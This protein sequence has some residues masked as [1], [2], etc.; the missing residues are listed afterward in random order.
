MQP[1]HGS[2]PFRPGGAPVIGGVSSFGFASGAACRVAFGLAR[3][4]ERVGV[5]A[6]SAFDA[7]QHVG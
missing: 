2:K 5:S 3:L 4:F 7:G 6:A 1:G